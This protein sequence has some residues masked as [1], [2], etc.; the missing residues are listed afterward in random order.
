MAQKAKC[1]EV[2]AVGICRIGRLG[3]SIIGDVGIRALK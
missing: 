2:R 1:N 3:E